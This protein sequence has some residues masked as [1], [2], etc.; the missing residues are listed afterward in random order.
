MTKQTKRIKHINRK[1]IPPIPFKNTMMDSRTNILTGKMPTLHKSLSVHNNKIRTN[2]HFPFVIP[3]L[4]EFIHTIK[5][6]HWNTH[7]YG[8]HKSIDDFHSS[9][10]SKVDHF[11]EILLAKSEYGG[12]S[13]LIKP[14]S[15]HIRTFNDKHAFVLYLNDFKHFLVG[16]SLNRIFNTPSNSDISAIKDEMLGDVNQLLYLL[17]LNK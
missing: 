17:S 7:D 12:R 1:M 8:M 3:G 4:L 10:S 15:L 6:H 13:K 2:I 11:V 9:I 5:L 14:M 16:L